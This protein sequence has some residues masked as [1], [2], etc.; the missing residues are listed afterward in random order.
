MKFDIEKF[1]LL[2]LLIAASA[3]AWAAP[4]PAATPEHIDLPN[5]IHAT[6]YDAD[7]LAARLTTLGGAPAIQLDDGRYVPVITDIANPAIAN[8][9]DGQFHA[10]PTQD[11]VTTLRAISNPA[12]RITVRIYELPFPRPNILVS[13]TSGADMFLSPQVLDVDP[14]VTAYIVSHEMGHV[15]HNRFMP[16]GGAA[17]ANYERLRGIDDPNRFFD[18]ASHAYRPKEIFAE[19]FR[20]LFGAPLGRMDGRVENPEIALPAS[21]NGLDAFYASVASGASAKTPAIVA[22]SYPNPFNPSTEI[23]VVVPQELV[24]QSAPVSIRVFSVTG[25]LVKDL[26]SGSA[27]GDFVAR[28][29]G[30][31]RNGNPV[32]SSTYYAAIQVGSARETVKLLLLK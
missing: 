32:A 24:Q 25:A 22:S 30:T 18:T 12:D 31:D 7:Y 15:F 9:G 27:V 11:V 14:M 20:V 16:D 21:V 8:K 6:I 2:G 5:G 28:W 13:S 3:G 19:D 10:F 29:D 17:W 1:G 23:R 4:A 26:Y